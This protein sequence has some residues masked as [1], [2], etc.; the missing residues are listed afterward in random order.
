MKLVCQFE[1]LVPL[2]GFVGV[3]DG[4]ILFHQVVVQLLTFLPVAFDEFRNEGVVA[5]V[6]GAGDI[7]G[8]HAVDHPHFE[9][10]RH[11]VPHQR[12]V[13]VAPPT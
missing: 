13:R 4:T 10:L 7:G 12:C 8:S 1:T 5:T 2:G 9:A 11:R 3:F 6:M